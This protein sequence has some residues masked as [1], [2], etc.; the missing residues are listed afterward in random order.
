MMPS[1]HKEW[2]SVLRSEFRQECYEGTSEDCFPH[3]LPPTTHTHTKID[4]RLKKKGELAKVVISHEGPELGRDKGYSVL[5]SVYESMN[6]G[7][8]LV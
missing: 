5:I 2:A 7:W 3:C 4:G 1:Y 6:L 8:Q